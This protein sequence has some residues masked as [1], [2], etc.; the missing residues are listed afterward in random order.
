[1]DRY[2]ETTLTVQYGVGRPLEVKH[3]RTNDW[4]DRGVP[5]QP[6]SLL[7]LLRRVRRVSPLFQL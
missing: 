2:D 4:P 5:D 7:R 1:M 3:Y 6:M